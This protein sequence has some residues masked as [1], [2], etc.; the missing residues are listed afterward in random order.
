MKNENNKKQIFLALVLLL[1][2]SASIAG[3]NTLTNYPSLRVKNYQIFPYNYSISIINNSKY[4]SIYKISP[5]DDII[6]FK[7]GYWRAV[8]TEKEN[9]TNKAAK[10]QLSNW[11][12]R[13]FQNLLSV[14]NK[15]NITFI[16][17]GDFKV[18]YKILK[19]STGFTVER[20]IAGLDQ[21][22]LKLT[23]TFL[24]STES[25]V[26]D[27][28]GT[29]HFKPIQDKNFEKVPLQKNIN[30]L[31]NKKVCYIVVTEL[32]APGAVLIPIRDGEQWEISE[33][34]KNIQI[35]EP[36][37][38]GIDILQSKQKIILYNSIN[39]FFASKDKIC[40]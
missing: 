13:T 11:F 32:D 34:L 33:K 38:T 28:K 12:Y 15:A 31:E 6:T 29:V 36:V 30:S 5:Y 2:F 1:L 10:K 40:F 25:L 39:E 9:L 35:D 37:K 4:S 16:T 23:K 21:K 27:S 20:S 26:F 24:F 8:I 3:I 22:A 19:N 14:F 7:S 18:D 17:D